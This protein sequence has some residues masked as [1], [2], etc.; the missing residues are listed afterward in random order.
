MLY[1][2]MLRPPSFEATLVSVDTQKAEQMGATVVH[3]GNFVGV[4]APSSRAG[5]GRDR[6]PFMLSGSPSRSL[7]TRNCSTIFEKNTTDG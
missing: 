6:Q 7:R 3:D 5:C 4:A 2:K 1:G